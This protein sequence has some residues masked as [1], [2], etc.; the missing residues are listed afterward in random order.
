MTSYGLIYTWGSGE[1]GQLG[2]GAD[3]ARRLQRR[4]VLP[5]IHFIPDSL[6][7]SVPLFVKRRCDRTLGEE[8]NGFLPQLVE[9]LTDGV[10]G[11]ISL[12]EHHTAVCRGTRVT[13]ERL[14]TPNLLG[15]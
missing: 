2:H 14:G 11:Q 8:Q 12:G 5:L 15:T 10:V 7:Y 1:S 13:I 3:R 6:T 4:F 9:Q